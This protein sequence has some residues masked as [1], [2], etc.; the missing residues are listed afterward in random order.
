M[1]IYRVKNLLIPIVML[2]AASAAM[3]ST[4][5]GS[6]D[7]SAT[8]SSQPLTHYEILFIGNSHSSANG[9]PGLVSTLIEAG[10]ENATANSGLA[11]GLG[12]LAD[13]LNDAATLKSLDSRAWTHVV[14]QA[15]KYSTTGLYTY[16]TDA[17]EE[18][19]RRVKARGALPILF[20]EWPRKGNTEEGPRVHQLHLDIA[21]REPACVAPIGLAWEEAIAQY[22]HLVLHA[23]DGNHSSLNGALLT[24]Y[25]LYQVITLQDASLLPDLPQIGVYVNIQKNLRDIAARVVKQNNAECAGPRIRI[26][27]DDLEFDFSAGGENGSQT[28]SVTSSGN[29]PVTVQ[30]IAG[31]DEPFFLDLAECAELPLTLPPAQSC[32]IEIRFDPEYEGHYLDSVA[33]RASHLST[34]LVIGLS[35][36]NGLAVPVLNHWG[37]LLLTALMAGSFVILRK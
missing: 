16:P 8:D 12:F 3:A 13:R 15:Q 31:P 9:L 24:A 4:R 6:S 34:P 37:M 18:W 11:P 7:V 30:S 20:P 1:S 17:A 35:G 22:P 23:A 25:V 28:L 26:D 27:P 2:M 33:V 29:L 10:V 14:L 5:S 36:F 19:I 32:A 21:S